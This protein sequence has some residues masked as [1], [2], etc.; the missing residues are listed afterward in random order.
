LR[1]SAKG[2]NIPSEGRGISPLSLFA[3]SHPLRMADLE[4]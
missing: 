4:K 1:G 2:E 3:S